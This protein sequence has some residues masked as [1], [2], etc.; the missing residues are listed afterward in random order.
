MHASQVQLHRA[1]LITEHS[2]ESIRLGKVFMHRLS[3]ARHRSHPDA[4]QRRKGEALPNFERRALLCRD[5]LKC[6]VLVQPA[7]A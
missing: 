7:Q 1:I 6:V 5:E 3:I 2:S 4:I